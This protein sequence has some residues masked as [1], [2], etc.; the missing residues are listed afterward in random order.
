[1]SIDKVGNVDMALAQF[2]LK[3]CKDL[4]VSWTRRLDTAFGDAASRALDDRARGEFT[5]EF[6]NRP[7]L[8]RAGLDKQHADKG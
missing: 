8:P 5:S 1:M 3:S 2:F 4:Q 7:D 6:M